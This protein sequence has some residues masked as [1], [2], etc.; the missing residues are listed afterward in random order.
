LPGSFD[1]ANGCTLY[2]DPRYDTEC[3]YDYFYLDFYNGTEWVTLATFNASSNNPGAECGGASGGN[4]D[5]WGNTDSGQPNSADWQERSNPGYPAFSRVI[6]PDTLI[7]TSGPEF[8]WRFSSDGAWSDADGRGDTDGAAFVDNVWVFGDAQRYFEDF[9]TG[10]LDTNYWSLPDPDPVRDGWH[11]AH[12]PDPPYEGGDGGDVTSC[13]LDSSYV[14]RGRPEGGYTQPGK[15]QWYYRLMTPSVPIQNTGC[16]IQYDEFECTLDYTCDYTDTKVRFYDSD[17]AKWCPWTDI[18]GFI[19]PTGCFFWNFNSNEDVSVFYSATAESVQ[20]GW[21][22]MD[23]STPGDFCHGKHK[24]T[25]LQVDNVS[26]GFYDAGATKFSARSIDMLHDTFFD[27]LCGFNSFFDAYNSDTVSHYSGPPYDVPIP[28]E[29]QLYVSVTDLDLLQEVRLY[30]SIDKGS[31][32]QSVAMQLDIPKD[33]GNPAL[34]GDYYGTLC[35]DDFGL[36]TWDT[37]TEVWYYLRA[38]DQLSDYEY[39]PPEADPGHAYHTGKVSD[40]WAFSIL[41]IYPPTYTGP[42]ILL[43]DGYNRDNYDW[44]PCVS[45]LDDIKPLEDIYEEILT[46]AGYC[47]DKY[48]INGAGSNVHIHPIWYSDYDAVVWFTG[49]YFTN[50]LFDAEAQGNLTTYLADGGK[51]VLCGDRIAYAMDVVA[52]DSLGGEFLE[53]VMGCDYLEEAEGAF[54]KPYFYAQAVETVSVF[55]TPMVVG[56]TLLDSLLIY[57]ECP[58]LKDMSY[59]R[60]IDP[61]WTGYTAQPL[62]RLL[63]PDP[64]ND[65]AHMAIYTESNDLGQC[66]FVNVDLCAVV[67]H[68]R[69]YCD[70]DAQTPAPNFDAGTYDGSVELMRTI[71]E[72]LF[73]LPS[74]PGGGAADVEEPAAGGLWPRTRLIRVSVP[75]RSGMRLHALAGWRSRCT[76]PGVR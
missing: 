3:K 51:V 2:F 33:P 72:D 34:G 4:P 53:G 35:P 16:V 20:F 41:P 49:P 18:D 54:A 75:P 26:I 28:R 8:R 36:G 57:R 42:R 27:N 46:D 44:S 60:T 55:G 74:I 76:M 62:L 39:W 22:L 37:G 48:D 45:E 65:P 47:Y 67:N 32:W 66:V 52:E 40:Y 71:L 31:S 24:S 7:L 21:E 56:P 64:Y 14:W 10:I 69:I 5:Y 43:V 50:Y 12:D 61:P 15:N 63:N 68:E 13:T 25:E 30:G 9:E 59:V 17:Q 19:I 73:G 29:R 23:V 11:L 1:V 6:P 70:G 58:Y 38:E